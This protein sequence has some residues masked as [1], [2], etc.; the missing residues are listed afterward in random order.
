MRP[1][2]RRSAISSRRLP[3]STMLEI[4][5]K[6]DIRVTKGHLDGS[7]ERRPSINLI[8]EKADYYRHRQVQHM[9]YKSNKEARA[10]YLENEARNRERNKRYR[11]NRAG[12]SGGNSKLILV[13]VGLLLIWLAVHQKSKAPANSGIRAYPA[14]ARP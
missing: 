8:S 11:E 7:G 9:A 12:K 10:E 5:C 4:R 14:V 3:S 13:I 2:L 1:T 6:S